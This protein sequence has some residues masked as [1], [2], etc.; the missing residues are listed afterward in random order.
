[1]NNDQY[2]KVSVI[3]FVHTPLLACPIMAARNFLELK[4]SRKNTK[5]PIQELKMA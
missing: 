1:L 5:V 2:E 4:P 3:K